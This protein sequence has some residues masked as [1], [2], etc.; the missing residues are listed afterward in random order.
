[1]LLSI[2][3]KPVNIADINKACENELKQLP[4]IS[5]LLPIR[6]FRWK[7]AIYYINFFD[8][9][10]NKLNLKD[11]QLE[12]LKE[13]VTISDNAINTTV[14]QKNEFIIDFSFN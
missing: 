12:E 8:Q 1:M 7:K 3:K 2:T 10:Q 14:K 4:G 5:T 6:L 11:C 13:Y 9:M